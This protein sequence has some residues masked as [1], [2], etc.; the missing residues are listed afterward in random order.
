MR[1]A[2]LVAAA[3]VGV[4]G[5]VEAENSPFGYNLST[6]DTCAGL[7]LSVSWKLEEAGKNKLSK[8]YKISAD[9][10]GNTAEV[11]RNIVNDPIDSRERM[12][13]MAHAFTNVLNT[14][15]TN[16]VIRQCDA[17]VPVLKEVNHA[18]DKIGQE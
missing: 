12:L 13:M 2:L 16:D 8:H 6:Y 9:I 11:E 1:K 17:M 4:S 18:W 10:H 15:N 7:L 14:G 3:V 5:A